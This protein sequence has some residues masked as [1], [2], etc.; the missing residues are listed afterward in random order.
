M[1][2]VPVV[3]TPGL[4]E[5]P[6]HTAER[7]NA[8]ASVYVIDGWGD[9]CKVGWSAA[10]TDR[11]SQLQVSTPNELSLAFCLW[12]E[13]EGVAKFVERAAHK[14]LGAHRK[15]GE[16]FGVSADVA[17]DAIVRAVADGGYKYIAHRDFEPFIRQSWGNLAD[18]QALKEKKMR[19]WV[20]AGPDRSWSD[21]EMDFAERDGEIVGEFVR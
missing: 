13:S 5:K 6:Y 7:L 16:W 11:L 20:K 1:R 15:R 14:A 10:P 9:A 21:G 2:I 8:H 19:G 17:S 18:A 3:T 12:F 4:F